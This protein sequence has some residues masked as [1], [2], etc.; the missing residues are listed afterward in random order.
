MGYY[1]IKL[2]PFSRKPCTMVLPRG[3]Y[4]YQKF[5]I[6]LCNFLD[7]YQ[8]IMYKLFNGLDYVRTYIDVLLIISNK[9]LEDHIEKLDKMLSKLKS[10][11][12]KVNAE[13]SFVARNELECLGFK[14][15]RKGIVPLPDKVEAIK[16]ITVPTTKKQL[17]SLI[18]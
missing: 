5:P 17:Q 14:I 4:V 3:K 7:I 16:N 6:G 15:T 8:E 13:K 10:A 18:W 12:F 9:S 11:G 1:H 2:C